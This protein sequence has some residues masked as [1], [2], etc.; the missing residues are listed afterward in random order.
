MRNNCFLRISC[1]ERKRIIRIEV[2][3]FTVCLVRCVSSDDASA[4]QGKS[5]WEKGTDVMACVF[6][7][8]L[9]PPPLPPEAC[10]LHLTVTNTNTPC[11]WPLSTVTDTGGCGVLGVGGGEQ[12][13]CV[14]GVDLSWLDVRG[15]KPC[16]NAP[17]LLTATLWRGPSKVVGQHGSYS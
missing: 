13:H 4:R 7:R 6:Q 8:S 12:Q 9:P 15:E 2:I 3:C 11:K 5:V 1:V 17:V 14:I 10:L 16:S